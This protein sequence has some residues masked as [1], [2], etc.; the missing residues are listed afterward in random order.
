MRLVVVDAS[1]RSI[2]GALRAKRHPRAFAVTKDE[3]TA[4][5]ANTGLIEGRELGPGSVTAFRL[6][7]ITKSGGPESES[8]ASESGGS[9]GAHKVVGE[10]AWEAV[11]GATLWVEPR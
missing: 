1:T 2:I 5:L 10:V 6:R 11:V 4:Y 3:Q 8:A 9:W 7:R